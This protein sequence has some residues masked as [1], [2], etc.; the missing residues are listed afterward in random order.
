MY[1]LIVLRLFYLLILFTH[2]IGH[3]MGGLL[4]RRTCDV[5]TRR[6]TVY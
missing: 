1:T 5:L 4:T 3:R 2:T 6:T